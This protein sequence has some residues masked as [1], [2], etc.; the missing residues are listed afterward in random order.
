VT[1]DDRALYVAFRCEESLLE[2]L[3][4]VGAQK[5]DDIWRGDVVEVFLSLGED[6]RPYR[7]FIVNPRNIQWDGQSGPE[8]DDRHWNA[9]WRSAVHLGENEWT[10]EMAIPWKALGGRPAPGSQRRANLCRQRTPVRELSTWSV[11][12]RGFLEA[13]RF[14]VWRFA[15]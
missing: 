14:G 3:R 9:D 11:V 8:G 5:D 12:V 15:G 10:V 7:H 1:Y 4:I 6:P 2:R 13:E